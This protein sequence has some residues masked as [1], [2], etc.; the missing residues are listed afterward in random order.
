MFKR[1]LLLVSSAALLFSSGAFAQSFETSTWTY[2]GIILDVSTDSRWSSHKVNVEIKVKTFYKG[3]DAG[4]CS[5]GGDVALL[6]ITNS[7]YATPGTVLQQ[8]QDTFKNLVLLAKTTGVPV[9]VDVGA[10]CELFDMR[11]K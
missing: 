4:S 9:V 11:L 8:R 5:K 10:N 2:E 1:I 7:G 6:S 3:K